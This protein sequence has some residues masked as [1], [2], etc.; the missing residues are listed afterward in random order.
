MDTSFLVK[1]EAQLLGAEPV[2]PPVLALAAVAFLQIAVQ[3]AQ[4]GTLLSSFEAYYS[5]YARGGASP[6]LRA[7]MEP[8]LAYKDASEPPQTLVPPPARVVS[9]R[10]QAGQRCRAPGPSPVPSGSTTCSAAPWPSP[11]HAAA[12]R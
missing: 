12:P 4:V 11:T 7:Q 10:A 5:S 1:H 9:S 3:R 6:A 2:A 8:A